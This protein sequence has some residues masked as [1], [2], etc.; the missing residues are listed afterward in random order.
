MG[1]SK[2]HK[3]LPLKSHMRNACSVSCGRVSKM[4][5]RSILFVF[6]KRNPESQQSGWPPGWHCFPVS[7]RDFV[8]TKRMGESDVGHEKVMKRGQTHRPRDGRPL[9]RVAEYSHSPATSSLCKI[10]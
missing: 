5:P 3:S 6:I 1:G 8:L 10:I 2:P 9:L 7:L 4:S